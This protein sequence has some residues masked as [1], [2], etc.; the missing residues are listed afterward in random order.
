[1]PSEVTTSMPQQVVSRSNELV[2]AAV[3]VTVINTLVGIA[4]MTIGGLFLQKGL[5]KL[6]MNTPE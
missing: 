4:F 2:N 3:G 1:M 6:F 5:P